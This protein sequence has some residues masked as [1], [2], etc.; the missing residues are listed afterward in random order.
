MTAHTLIEY[1]DPLYG[2][3]SDDFGARFFK[4]LKGATITSQ[5]A[6]MVVIGTGA[7][8]SS[9]FDGTT[10]LATDDTSVV[11]QRVLAPTATTV[12][13]EITFIANLSDGRTI[14]EFG[15]IRVRSAP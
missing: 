11:M 3:E 5:S 6:T 1:A 2:G 8:A 4:R 10:S 15:K 12:D 14:R 13:Y 9:H 7:D